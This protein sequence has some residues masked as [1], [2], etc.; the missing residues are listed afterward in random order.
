M[1]TVLLIDDDPV[2]AKLL[3]AFLERRFG[4]DDYELE[5][6]FDLSDGLRALRERRFDHVLLDNRLPPFCDFRQTLPVVRQYAKGTEPIL[7]SASLI[8]EC[9]GE[10][11]HFGDPAVIDKFRLRERIEGGL[12][13]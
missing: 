12:F 5:H 2:E 10:L 13:G 3:Q 1:V 11:E 7:V 8:D 9:F 4:P 6:A